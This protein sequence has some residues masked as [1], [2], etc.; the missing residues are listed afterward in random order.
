MLSTPMPS[1]ARQASRIACTEVCCGRI[2][3]PTLKAA[4]AAIVPASGLEL[5]GALELEARSEPRPDPCSELAGRQR[6]AD[7]IALGHVAAECPQ[8]PQSALG[9]DTL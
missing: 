7:V 8:Q 1:A 6:L 4:I 5:R 3:T 9:L 2:C